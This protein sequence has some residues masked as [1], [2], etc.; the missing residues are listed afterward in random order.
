VPRC[1]RAS[2]TIPQTTRR[3]FRTRDNA[4]Q[5]NRLGWLNRRLAPGES[6]RN[7]NSSSS[8][9]LL[10]GNYNGFALLAPLACWIFGVS[11]PRRPGRMVTRPSS[12]RP[13]RRE[14][15]YHRQLW[16]SGEEQGGMS[17]R[18]RR[19]SR[20]SWGTYFARNS[21]TSRH[22]IFRCLGGERGLSFADGVTVD[23]RQAL[24]AQ[25]AWKW[26]AGIVD[27][28]WRSAAGRLGKRA[29][30][31][32]FAPSG[33]GKCANKKGADRHLFFLTRASATRFTGHRGSRTM[34]HGLLGLLANWRFQRLRG[35]GV[36]EQLQR[37]SP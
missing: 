18:F 12:W 13:R 15:R 25:F 28:P 9:I 1:H 10:P 3:H 17:E 29:F 7:R 32:F 21:T 20:L 35:C 37:R 33:D 31:C 34:P 14:V 30:V 23:L 22:R 2:A 8:G 24:A 19:L 5:T 26:F 27:P 16:G 6:I 4:P 36:R 11:I